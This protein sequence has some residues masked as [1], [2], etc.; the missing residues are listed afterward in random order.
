MFQWTSLLTKKHGLFFRRHLKSVHLDVEELWFLLVLVQCFRKVQLIVL[1]EA[2]ARYRFKMEAVDRSLRDIRDIDNPNGDFVVLYG[3]DFHQI[4]PAVV[5][6]DRKK[7]IEACLRCSYLFP[8][9]QHF[10]LTTNVCLQSHTNR[11]LVTKSTKYHQNFVEVGIVLFV[12]IV[13]S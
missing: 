3:S 11:K 13:H 2:C 5:G 1:E 10:H 12:L 4:L 9:M 8:L 6:G 7:T